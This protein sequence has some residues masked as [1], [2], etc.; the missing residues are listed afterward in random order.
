[1][2]QNLKKG[3]HRKL[4]GI[5]RKS[6]R[7]LTPVGLVLSQRALLIWRERPD[8]NHSFDIGT[9]QG[10][11]AMLWWYLR[12]G[13]SELQ[14]TPAADEGGLIMAVNQSYPGV[15]QGSFTPITWLMQILSEHAPE[16]RRLN[17]LDT[18]S[19]ENFLA[20]FFSR[21]LSDAHLETFL[22]DEQAEALIAA[23]HA[24]PR[25]P[26]L[27]A[28]LW[29]SDDHLRSVYIS[30]ESDDFLGWCRT[31]GALAYPVLYHPRL[32]PAVNPLDKRDRTLPFGV[33]LIGHIHSRSGVSEDV[34]A[35]VRVLEAASIPYVVCDVHPGA[36]MGQEEV[37][38]V[39]IKD[40]LPYAITMACMTA[41][42]TL[43]AKRQLGR[44]AFMDRHVIGY[45]PWELPELPE[46][47][48]HAYDL[49]SEIW[50]S[51]A[52]TYAA[53]CRSSPVPVRAM[54]MAVTTDETTGA[55]RSDFGLPINTFLF[56]FAFDGLSGF[57]R[58]APYHCVDA[59]QRAFP[60][61]AEP[62]GL[63]IKAMR[64][65]GHPHWDELMQIATQDDR[66][67]LVEQSLT[68][69]VLLDLW[70]SLDCFVSLHRS[71]GFGR[72]IAEAMRLGVPVITTA[73][74]G[75]M[76]FTTHHTAALV[77][78]RLKTVAMGE[79]P[80]GE[81]QLWAEPDL[82]CAADHM[83]RM[84]TDRAWREGLSR[85]GQ[86]LVE[87][88]YGVEAVAKAWTPVLHDIY[89]AISAETRD[90]FRGDENFN[91]GRS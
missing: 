40:D 19:Q 66:I 82:N 29:R 25:V 5:F 85:Q 84:V 58:K 60:D 32:A 26:R 89:A 86:A 14:L 42:A 80:F 28:C 69:P 7:P 2:N 75:N 88:L 73:H 45:W 87:K 72:N 56:G 30:P 74:S 13:F 59:F 43:L 10:K 91:R 81:G 24:Y 83:R 49:V 47:W 48:H 64:V 50:S 33:N 38:T 55:N 71:E 16:S 44:A 9:A 52:F 1:M 23:D 79:Y 20:W 22:S 39:P 8:L 70:R 34:R 46:I 35:A 37:A 17:L 54:P 11:A 67:H 76:D 31:Q 65:Q 57:A 51:T 3:W 61:R 12:H 4:L 6:R 27:L 18:A 53:L 63:V 77:P 78:A 62:V 41:E 15:A 36:A 21:G 68:R 90:K